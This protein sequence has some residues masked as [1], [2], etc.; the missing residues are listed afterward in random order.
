MVNINAFNS[1]FSPAELR[2]ASAGK[3]EQDVGYFE[4]LTPTALVGDVI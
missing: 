2:G 1:N 4:I 3:F